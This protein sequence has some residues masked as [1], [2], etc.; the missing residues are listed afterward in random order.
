MAGL[1]AVVLAAGEG[2]RLRPLTSTR[3]KHMIPIGGKPLLEHHLLALRDSGIKDVLLIVNYKADQIREYFGDGSRLGM[4]ISYA[5]QREIK[6]TANAFSI[7]E[8]YVDG[9]FIATYGDL[10]IN[11]EAVKSALNLH[12]KEH[13]AATITT[14]EI[15]NPEQYAAVKL[16]QRRVVEIIEKPKP[17]SIISRQANA[18]V[19]VFSQEIFDAIRQT[20]YSPRGEQEITDSIKILIEREEEVLAA[21]ISFDDWLDVGRP[22]DILEANMRILRQIEHEVLGEV[23][24]GAYVW[25]PIFVDE[26]ARIRSGAY[27]EGPAYIG[28]GSDIGP[29][30]Y[31]R[32]YTSIGRNVRVGNACEIKNSILMDHVHIG[33]L[34]YVGDSIIGEN[35]NLGAGTITANLRFD[36]RPVKMKVK[37]EVIS[38]GRRK[39]GVIMGDSVKTGIG[40]LFM[41]GVKIGYNSWIGPNIVVYRDIPSNTIVMLEQQIQRKNR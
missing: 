24:K 40:S 30:C 41:P 2:K 22:W 3:P 11:A 31:I 34:S 39:M 23:E 27:I 37:G 29:N 35:C 6:G 17:G 36:N 9:D 33:H 5:Y 1:K 7:A 15:E 25:G 14:V 26:D 10:L 16:E 21:K 18:G 19:Y 12:L 8:D 20:G 28:R 13:P 4:R 38:T 32:P